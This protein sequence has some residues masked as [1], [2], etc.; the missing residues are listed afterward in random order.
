MGLLYVW[1]KTIL[2]EAVPT[3]KRHSALLALS[4]HAHRTFEQLSLL[5]IIVSAELRWT[6]R[7]LRPGKNGKAQTRVALN[8]PHMYIVFFFPH[9]A[10]N[11][12]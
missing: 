5:I 12:F 11:G 10:K 8:F 3:K 1:V 7:L 2:I 6:V 4:K 9:G